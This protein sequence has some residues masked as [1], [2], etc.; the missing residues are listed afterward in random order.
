MLPAYD[1]FTPYL[2]LKLKRNSFI[3]A[4]AIC[5]FSVK[6]S[7]LELV[8]LT[9]MVGIFMKDFKALKRCLLTAWFYFSPAHFHVEVLIF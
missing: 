1:F 7:N 5:R 2:N 8:T 3:G 9:F 6:F 4:G